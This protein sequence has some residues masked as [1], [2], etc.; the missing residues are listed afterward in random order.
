MQTTAPVKAHSKSASND[1]IFSA[2][3]SQEM[4]FLA[5][6]MQ[7]FAEDLHDLARIQQQKGKKKT[8][9]S[10]DL[11]DTPTKRK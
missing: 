11:L 5:Q 10:A 2:Y 1:S 3:S 9:V 7:D 4:F 8:Y 6:K